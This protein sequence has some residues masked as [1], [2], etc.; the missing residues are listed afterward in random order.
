MFMSIF[1]SLKFTKL[2]INDKRF[3]T[4]KTVSFNGIYR[5][6]NDKVNDF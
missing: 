3:N 4:C 5:S 2:M 1:S 6:F